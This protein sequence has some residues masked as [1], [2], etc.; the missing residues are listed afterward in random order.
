MKKILKKIAVLLIISVI[1]ISITNVFADGIQVF[2][3]GS[4]VTLAD[5]QGRIVEPF[6]QNGTTYVP[7]RGISERLGCK[8]EWDEANKTVKIYKDI[9]PD[10]SVFRN[11][12][13]DVKVYI[14]NEL[15]ELK[16]ANGTIVK[17]ITLND[18]NYIPIR[19]VSEALGCQVEWDGT[20]QRVSVYNMTVSPNGATLD[21][22]RPYEER[23]ELF[24]ES[25]G[26]YL[27]IDNK[28]YTNAI[29]PWYDDGKAL[30][31]IN[32]KYNSVSFVAGFLENNEITGEIDFIV[33]GNLVKTITC[34]P[35]T[36]AREYQVDINRGLQL[37]IMI[38]NSV[39][40]G[41]VVFH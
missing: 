10:G 36:P 19:G 8:V 5:A 16:D 27:E 22:V 38:D 40:L 2:I 31:N 34:E 1:C 23:A 18:T 9:N 25:E 26:K 28:N 13:K 29:R 20:L 7:L 3:D 39:G 14:D 21:F 15:I 17:P 12:D 41:N 30:F 6:I 4:L 24:Y 32:G 11:N 33:D 37:K 35:F